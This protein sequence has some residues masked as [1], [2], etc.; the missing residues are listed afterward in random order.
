[1]HDEYSAGIISYRV[2]RGRRQD[3]EEITGVHR[4]ELPKLP[5]PALAPEYQNMLLRIY[6]LSTL[7]ASVAMKNA[8]FQTICIRGA[9][10]YLNMCD[11]GIGF[12]AVEHVLVVKPRRFAPGSISG[13]YGAAIYH[14]PTESEQ[15]PQS[16][17]KPPDYRDE[18]EPL[19]FEQTAHSSY[20][21]CEYDVSYYAAYSDGEKM[22]E[23]CPKKRLYTIG[24][25]QYQFP[26]NE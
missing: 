25:T 12:R 11:S 21:I 5:V 15:K 2:R 19:S 22:W 8:D 20:P 17:I 23:V 13:R 26:D 10:E 18:V 3:G 9:E 24:G 4:I 1:M 6:F 16:N 7:D 14:V